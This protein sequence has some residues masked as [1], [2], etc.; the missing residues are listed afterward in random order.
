MMFDTVHLHSFLVC[1]C[2]A[3]CNA[4]LPVRGVSNMHRF[5]HSAYDWFH[6]NVQNLVSYLKHENYIVSTKSVLTRMIVMKIRYFHGHT[7]IWPVPIIHQNLY[8][9][10]E[11]KFM[12]QAK[13]CT[14]SLNLN[15]QKSL[16][17][18]NQY[19]NHVYHA[20]Y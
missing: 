1:L 5:S 13:L 8:I 19:F 14:M 10:Y 3:I 16:E 15:A 20:K 9:S 11:D 17:S 18:R 4:D 7:E 2:Y 6:L 12:K